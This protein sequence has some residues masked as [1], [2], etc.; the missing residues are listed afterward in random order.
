LLGEVDWNF[1]LSNTAASFLNGGETL[2]LTYHVTINDPAGGT[3]EQDVTVTIL[4]VNHPVVITSGPE[5]ASVSELADTTGSAAID[6]TTVVP[7]GTLNFTDADTGNT[8]TVAASVASETWSG[9]ATVP[10][11]TQADLAAALTTTL[12]DSTGTGTGS[13]DWNFGIADKDLDFLAAS[14]TLT[15]NYNVAVSDASTTATQT[16]SVTITGAND[17][18]MVTSGPESASVTELANTTDSTALDTTT[19][20]PTGTLAF[21][22]VDL[23]DSHSVSVALD[24]AVWSVDP[25]FV[26]GET[27]ADLQAALTTAL[28]DSTGSGTG[29]VD[30]SFSIPDRDLDFLSAGETDDQCGQPPPRS[31]IANA[32]HGIERQGTGTRERD[33]QGRDSQDQGVL[34][35]AVVREEAL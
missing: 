33:A 2:T 23:T 26:P 9:G 22:D 34:V 31:R 18:V 17:P 5:S 6:T 30:W 35:A 13:V 32:E 21:S 11:V 27:L 3:A 20:V 19:P 15:V 10:A 1:A 29:G 4:G 28:Q 12:H 24:S 8:H 16:V 7:A 25:N 14:E